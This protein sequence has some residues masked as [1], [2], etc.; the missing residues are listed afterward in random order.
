[1]FIF[2][3]EWLWL[4]DVQASNLLQVMKERQKHD[5]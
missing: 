5:A 2:F 4:V 3:Q 1:M